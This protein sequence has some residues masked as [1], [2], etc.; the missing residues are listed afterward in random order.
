MLSPNRFV[1][2]HKTVSNMA[3]HRSHLSNVYTATGH[4]TNEVGVLTSPKAQSPAEM[5]EIE[6]LI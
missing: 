6:K 4:L 3:I 5:V 2:V 1:T